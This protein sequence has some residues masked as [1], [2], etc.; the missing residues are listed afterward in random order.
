MLKSELQSSRSV[1]LD[2]NDAPG[3]MV[4]TRAS[5][6]CSGTELILTKIYHKFKNKKEAGGSGGGS[7]EFVPGG[8]PC[9]PEARQAAPPFQAA[10]LALA[11]PAD[12]RKCV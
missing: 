4:A 9:A 7:P 1:Y 11:G 10:I 8:P 6:G 12:L 5:A 3:P 2:R